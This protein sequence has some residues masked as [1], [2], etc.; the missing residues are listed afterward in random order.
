MQA[1]ATESRRDLLAARQAT[2]AARQQVEVAVGQYYPSVSLSADLF[3]YRES[4]PDERKWQGLLA[5]NLPIF[6]AGLIE[7]DVRT[8]WSQFRQAALTEQAL[9]RQVEQ[10]VRIAVQ[11]LN[12]TERRIAE[13]GTQLQAAQQ[14]FSQAD[15]SYNVGLATNLERVTAQDQLLS[16]QLQ[17]TSA[18]FDR[19]LAYLELARSTGRLR[20][21]LENTPSTAA[22]TMTTAP[23]TSP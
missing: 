16:A 1:T 14:A 4:F 21:R 22:T 6:S 2:R 17:L 23:T 18:H 13:L 7:A 12:S 20:W 9:R 8:A 11:N 3:L 15:Q 5:A 10:D 19:T